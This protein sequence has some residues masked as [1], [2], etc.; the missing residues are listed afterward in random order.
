MYE[1]PKNFFVLAGVETK[2]ARIQVSCT[3]LDDFERKFVGRLLVLRHDDIP[4]SLQ[5]KQLKS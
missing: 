2:R 1:M 4:I 5:F 3:Q